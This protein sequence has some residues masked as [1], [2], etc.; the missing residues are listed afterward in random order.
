MRQRS[1]KHGGQ[2]RTAVVAGVLGVVEHGGV[3][4]RV[5]D[6]FEVDDPHR[7]A[8]ADA[9]TAR[10]RLLLVLRICVR[11]IPACSAI[12]RS[13]KLAH[14]QGGARKAEVEA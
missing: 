1:V 5:C 7:L 4:R 13:E 14:N 11:I 9:V 12:E 6:C 10:H 2:K 8:L 3:G